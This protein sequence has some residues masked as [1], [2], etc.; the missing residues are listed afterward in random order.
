MAEI[1]YIA[2]FLALVASVYSVAAFILGI[3]RKSQ[4]L[5]GSARNSLFAVCGLISISV[6]ILIYALVAHNFQ[7]EYVY[8]YTSHDLSLP[9][10]ISAFWAGNDGSL[11]FWAWL[12]SIFATVV[13]VR[14]WTTHE[15]LVP[16]ASVIILITEVFFLA[17]LLSVSNPFQQISP[18]PAEGLGLNPLLQ[19]IGMILHP[20]LLLS[21]YAG[22]TVPFAF[23]IAALL[24]RQFDGEWLAVMRRWALLAWLLLGM[25]NIIGAWWAY[26]ELGWG[27]YWAWDPVE[28]AGLMPWLVATAFLHSAAMQRRKGVLKAWSMLLVI[29]TFGLTIF[30]TFLTRSGFLSS[31]HAFSESTL[32]IFFLVFISVVLFGSLVLLYYRN[33]D[34]QSQ[35]ETIPTI[36]KENAFLL[37]NLLL[38]GAVLVIFVG[39]ISPTLSEMVSGVKIGVN[40]SFFNGINGPI[41]L[42]V[43]LL[44]GFC[45]L[46][47]WRKTSLNDLMRRFLWPAGI[48]MILGATL[49]IL[50]IRGWYPLVAFSLCGFVLSAIIYGW[51]RESRAQHQVLGGNFLRSFWRL[52]IAN[53]PRYGGYIVHIAMVII[54]IGVIGSSF[55]DVERSIALKPGGIATV[56]GYTLVY[57]GLTRDETS[58]KIVFRATLSVSRQGK[59]VGQLVPEQHFPGGYPPVAEVAI[60][61]TPL[62]DLYVI[63]AGWDAEGS[64]AFRVLVN[65]LVIWIWIGGGLL[66]IGG[67]IAF[68]PGGKKS[69][70]V[71]DGG[72]GR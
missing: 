1:G 28:N 30:G 17:L 61:V 7:I 27:G 32:G 59:L 8:R 4:V 5:I 16:Y 26:I 18:V 24:S 2:L 35:A 71:K 64:A 57:E 50:G 48:A 66:L 49:F 51:F 65:P 19:N 14:R 56:K 70:D 52:F 20:P 22:F 42:A 13:V 36:S 62:E 58:Q 12:L 38:V 67:L 34:L 47:G 68:W 37:S 63:L 31:I 69:P 40:P 21:G 25:G 45:V 33:R 43:I 6:A 54:A 10:L 44:A 41:F 72:V 9:Y 46:I 55:F 39:T 15:T 29:V 3:R 11:L 23:V 60:H 53:R